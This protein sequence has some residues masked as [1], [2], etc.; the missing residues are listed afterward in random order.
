MAD[1]PTRGQLI[2]AVMTLGNVH[3]DELYQMND[4]QLLMELFRICAKYRDVVQIPGTRRMV[5]PLVLPSRRV[6]RPDNTAKPL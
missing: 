5:D 1:L 4:R 3:P 6:W 2:A